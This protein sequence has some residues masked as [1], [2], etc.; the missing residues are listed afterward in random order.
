MIKFT[1]SHKKSMA[2]YF[3]EQLT[4]RQ[5]DLIMELEE[6]KSMNNVEIEEI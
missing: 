6:E 3:A 2:E 5:R 4:I 1:V